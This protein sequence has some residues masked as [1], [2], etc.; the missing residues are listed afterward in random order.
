MIEHDTRG[1]ILRVSLLIDTVLNTITSIHPSLLSTSFS[2]YTQNLSVAHFQLKLFSL[3]AMAQPSHSHSNSFRQPSVYSFF[4][5]IHSTQFQTAMA[6]EIAADPGQQP[7]SK[8]ATTA[9]KIVLQTEQNKL[10][11]RKSRERKKAKEIAEGQRDILTGK[12]VKQLDQPTEESAD[13]AVLT[14]SLRWKKKKVPKLRTKVNWQHQLLWP[15]IQEAAL[16]TGW[17]ARAIVRDLEL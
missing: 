4:K 17:R 14:N 12:P 2:S 6:Q 15:V 8:T 13:L 1:Y 10:C 7:H 5:K 9:E 3:V 11:Q 16:R